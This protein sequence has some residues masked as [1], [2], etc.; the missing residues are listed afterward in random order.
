LL[1][2][3]IFIHCII[4]LLFEEMQTNLS[5]SSNYVTDCLI[6]IRDVTYINMN[7]YIPVT[8]RTT[9]P[10]SPNYSPN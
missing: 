5:S 7:N 3:W 6:L 1:F 2:M 4:S 8:Y 9:V 10:C